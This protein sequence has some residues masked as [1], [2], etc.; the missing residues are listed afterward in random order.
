MRRIPLLLAL[1]VAG[2]S[3]SAYFS[4]PAEALVPIGGGLYFQSLQ[5]FG[6]NMWSLTFADADNLWITTGNGYGSQLVHSSDA[7]QTWQT[8]HLR[9]AFGGYLYGFKFLDSRHAR[10]LEA[11]QD[12]A[13][14]RFRMAIVASNNGGA[15]WTIKP[16]DIGRFNNWGSGLRLAPGGLHGRPG[17]RRDRQAVAHEA[18][19]DEGWRRSLAAALTRPGSGPS[20][21]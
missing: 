8:V 6:W 12:T 3:A 19:L 18:A 16:L 21:S 4:P 11:W 10:A 17:V 9:L 1:L 7:G 2:V 15:S 13:S 5:P 20:I 14:G